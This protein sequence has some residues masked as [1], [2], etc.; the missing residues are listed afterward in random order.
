V[1]STHSMLSTVTM[2]EVK[3]HEMK[4]VPKD[5]FDNNCCCR[6]GREDFDEKFNFQ[7]TDVS[8][9]LMVECSMKVKQC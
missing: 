3:Q 4:I 2:V 7:L 9:L 5:E 1:R 6:L 8:F